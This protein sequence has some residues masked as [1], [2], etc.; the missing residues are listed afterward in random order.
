MPFVKLEIIKGKSNEYKKELLQA[1]HEA[2]MLALEIDDE[3]RFQRLYELDTADFERR[4]TKTDK[5]TL[6][7]LDLYPGRSKEIKRK[8]IK[9][10]TRL[11]GERLEINASDIFIIIHE[12]SLDNWGS[13]GEQ[14]SELGFQYKKD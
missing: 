10:V 4:K 8:I 6:I 13:N 12:P 1:V 3:D 11:L 7:E 9:E 5:F 14:A 2:L